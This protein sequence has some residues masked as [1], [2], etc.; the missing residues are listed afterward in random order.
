MDAQKSEYNIIYNI[1]P[2]EPTVMEI[3]VGT[4][5]V[6]CYLCNIINAIIN[7]K[8]QH[9]TNATKYTYIG[10]DINPYAIQVTKDTL[11]KNNIIQNTYLFESDLLTNIP[12]NI[13]KNKVTIL[14]WN[15]PYVPSDEHEIYSNDI[16]TRSYAGGKDGRE[17]ID[18]MIPYLPNLLDINCG[19]FYIVFL[20]PQNN[21]QNFD[22]FMREHN[23]VGHIILVKNVGIEILA[24]LRYINTNTFKILHDMSLL[25]PLHD[26]SEENLRQFLRR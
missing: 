12:Q 21:L 14:V 26:V 7:K 5:I 11:I 23:M 25:N 16:L 20:Y 2:E 22:T 4:G 6:S 15:P 13:Y 9:N 1:L 3:G 19:L 8:Y 10:C 18:R 24:V 17:I